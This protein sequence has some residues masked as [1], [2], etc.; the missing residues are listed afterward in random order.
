VFYAGTF[1]KFTFMEASLRI[2]LLEYGFN[3]EMLALSDFY[4]N[5][6]I[7]VSEAE[8]L[9]FTRFW[10]AEHQSRWDVWATPQL[11]L[12]WLA[13]QTKSI[14]LGSA[15]ILLD[16]HSPFEVACDFNLLEQMFP[17][18]IDLGVARGKPF[19]S[20]AAVLRDSASDADFPGRIE[21]LMAYFSENATAI[22][23]PYRPRTP[24]LWTL[25]TSTISMRLALKHGLNYAHSIFHPFPIA[26]DPLREYASSRLNAACE[27]V[28]AV[29]G[30]CAPSNS[31]AQAI[32]ERR[33][34]PYVVPT[35]VGDIATCELKLRALLSETHAGEV[36]F[37]DVA[38]TFEEKLRSLRLLSR[39]ID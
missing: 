11:P 14:K 39:L 3:N 37:L 35:V 32:A 36:V 7:Y 5:L 29:A 9:G 25:G 4:S 28:L 20:N 1:C 15:G 6:L 21:K 10:L 26:L 12:M 19:P 27:A 38:T 24:N 33:S 31:A 23:L 8:N 22:L 18:R 16:Y 13:Q 2:G 34:N 17:G 30:I